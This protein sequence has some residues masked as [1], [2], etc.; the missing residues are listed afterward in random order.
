M[1]W[2]AGACDDEGTI[3]SFDNLNVTDLEFDEYAHEVLLGRV[4]ASEVHGI[5]R[6]YPSGRLNFPSR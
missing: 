1:A 5:T 4:P 3:F 2:C 6:L